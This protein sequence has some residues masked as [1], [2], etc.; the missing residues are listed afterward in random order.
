VQ[1]L[2]DGDDVIAAVPGHLLQPRQALRRHLR[3][4][5]AEFLSPAALT[6]GACDREQR[7]PAAAVLSRATGSLV[8]AWT[9]VTA[10]QDPTHCSNILPAALPLCNSHNTQPA[11]PNPQRPPPPACPDSSLMISSAVSTRPPGP[12][13]E[14][15]CGKTRRACRMPSWGVAACKG[16]RRA[17]QSTCGNT[18]WVPCLSKG[19]VGR[20]LA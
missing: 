7:L 17:R 6:A 10:I 15:V 13:N 1:R 4:R 20:P 16:G 9:G 18:K 19:E 5:R 2:Q 12:G 11:P 14:P 8:C 3:W